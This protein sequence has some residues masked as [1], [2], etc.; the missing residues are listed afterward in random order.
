MRWSDFIRYAEI[1]MRRVKGK[2]V[3]SLFPKGGLER[4]FTKFKK[5]DIF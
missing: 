3:L 1:L 5:R 2:R 4:L